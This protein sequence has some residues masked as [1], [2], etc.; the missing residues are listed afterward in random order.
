MV[1][2]SLIPSVALVDF[3][4]PLFLVGWLMGLRGSPFFF[5]FFCG[6]WVVGSV[7]RGGHKWWSP[8][9]EAS[10]VSLLA[11]GNIRIVGA[12]LGLFK[13]SWG[14]NLKGTIILSGLL[15]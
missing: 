9:W 8:A 3:Q 13:I 10:L 2:G 1:L 6:L 5:F 15:F 4:T 14:K 12:G 11:W 7:I